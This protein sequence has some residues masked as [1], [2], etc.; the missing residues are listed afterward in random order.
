MAGDQTSTNPQEPKKKKGILGWIIL[1]VGQSAGIVFFLI[2]LLFPSG[3][4]ATPEIVSTDPVYLA[5]SSCYEAG[6]FYDEA[7]QCYSV[8]PAPLSP[9]QRD[10]VRIAAPGTPGA[11]PSDPAAP[12]APSGPVD[13]AAPANPTDPAAPVDPSAPVDPGAPVN[14]AGPVAP[15]PPVAAPLDPG[16]T[17][18]NVPVDPVTGE[19]ATTTTTKPRATL[20]VELSIGFD[21]DPATIPMAVVGGPVDV[22]TNIDNCTGLTAEQPDV[23]L[24]YTDAAGSQDGGSGG[25]LRI[26]FEAADGADTT[27]VINDPYGTWWCNDN[28]EAGASDPMF[29][30]PD[31][32]YGIYDIWIGTTASGEFPAGKLRITERAI[33]PPN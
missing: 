33:T 26:L 20:R 32:P 23:V 28:W 3:A 13:P 6:L 29:T 16:T 25:P 14:P 1:I 5:Q 15:T 24:V 11:T 10:E 18:G 8:D 17:Q 30:I 2:R 12:G 19:P 31:G 27:L 21:P 4:A 9:T 7:G 22:T